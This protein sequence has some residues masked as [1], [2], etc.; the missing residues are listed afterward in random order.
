M[1][2]AALIKRMNKRMCAPCSDADLGTRL[3]NIG[4]SGNVGQN[5]M[6]GPSIVGVDLT[7]G[8]ATF[9]VQ[10]VDG[11]GVAVAG[12]YMVDFSV[13]DT[14]LGVPAAQTS[15]VVTTG[16]LIV[17]TVADAAEQVLTT[18]AGLALFTVDAGGADP[19]IFARASSGGLVTTLELA[20]TSV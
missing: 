15:I 19:D 17:E 18:A 10:M 11:D 2:S 20:I 7:D 12:V 3:A 1:L 6:P 4:D 13:A 8:T 16:T 5:A 9:S 14:E